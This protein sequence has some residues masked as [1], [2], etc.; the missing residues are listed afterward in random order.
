MLLKKIKI[1]ENRRVFTDKELDYTCIELFES[2]GIINYFKIDPNLFKH[3]NKYLENNDI[4]ILQ[5]P[6][7]NDLSFSYGKILSLKDNK[8]IHNSSTEDGSSGS[9]IIKRC[10]DNYIIGLHFG[11]VKKNK[12]E[13]KYNLATNYF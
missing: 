8:I 7:G 3:N 2:D 5:F 10:K 6:N 4:F 11:G 1:T 13:Y 9:P 12:N